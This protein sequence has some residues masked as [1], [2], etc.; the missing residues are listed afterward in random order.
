MVLFSYSREV[1][2]DF[3]WDETSLNA[4]GIIFEVSTGKLVARPYKKFFNFGEG[5]PELLPESFRPNLTGE[6]RVMEKLDGSL[7]I[8]FY[9]GG[10]WQVATKGSFESE[11]AIWANDWL[12]KNLDVDM[13]NTDYTYMFEIIYPQ[14]RIVIDYGEKKEMVLHGVINKHTGEEHWTE[15]LIEEGNRIHASVA[16]FYS[17][18]S[19]QEIQDLCEVL[20][21]QEEGFVITFRNGYKVKLKGKEYCRLHRI[22]SN[23]TEMGFWK[24][25][26]YNINGIPTDFLTVLPEE[27]RKESDRIVQKITHLHSSIDE[28]IVH[29]SA[30]CPDWFSDDEKEHKKLR[31]FWL[32]DNVEAEYITAV[33][34]LLNGNVSSLKEWIHKK[35]RDLLK[36]PKE[37]V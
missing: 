4:R 14:N 7:G 1:Q 25:W 3:K 37:E 2:Y 27:F 10:K 31:Y 15:Q 11:Q 32:R 21:G 13:M 33:L 8:V 5:N 12:Y 20:P 6:F 36:Q 16:K 35:V 34:M 19:I 28:K 23:I 30:Q 17:F 24:M 18:N 9:H 22:V 29:Y 26:D